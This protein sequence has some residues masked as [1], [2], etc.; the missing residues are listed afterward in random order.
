MIDTPTPTAF[1][2]N[3]LVAG[4]CSLLGFGVFIVT[5][6]AADFFGRVEWEPDATRPD[7]VRATAHFL[8]R[9]IRRHTDWH[10]VAAVL[11]TFLF[12]A[13]IV[14]SVLQLLVVGFVVVFLG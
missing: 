1:A 5:I 12:V 13:L 14:A 2:I 3:V 8:P 11:P 7:R 9:Y 10:E 4:A 6:Q